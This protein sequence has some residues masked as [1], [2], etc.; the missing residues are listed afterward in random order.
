MSTSAS[1]LASIDTAIIAAIFA[2]RIR[3]GARLGEVELATLF[4]VS[5]TLV[6]EAMFRLQ[7]RRIVEVRPRRGWFVVEPSAE[8]ARQ[9]FQARRVLEAGLM[10]ALPEVLPRE[11]IDVVRAHLDQEKQAID[12]DDRPALI[13]LMGDFHIRLVD[14][15][16]NSVL[17]EILRDLTARTILISTLYQSEEHAKES[18]RGHCLIFDAIEAGDREGAA[19]LAIRHLD[20]VEAGLRFDMQQDPLSDLRRSLGLPFELGTRARASGPCASLIGERAPSA[21]LVQQ[22]GLP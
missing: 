14:L 3:P 18:H 7:G 2:H 11:R 17:A 13:C 8:E 10:R 5:R 6:R 4:G 22:K 15:L 9:V 19:M 1:A 12:A 16:G 21:N 20:E